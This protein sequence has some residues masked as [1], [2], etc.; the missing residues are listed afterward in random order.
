MRILNVICIIAAAAAGLTLVALAGCAPDIPGPE[1]FVAP[2]HG[3]GGGAGNPDAVQGGGDSGPQACTSAA[4]CP[5]PT[6]PCMAAVCTKGV[7]GAQEAA[8]GAACSDGIDCTNGDT[9]KAGKC[10]PVQSVCECLLDSDCVLKNKGDLCAGQWVCNP[11]DHK[12]ILNPKTIV[13]CPSIADTQCLKTE[14]VKATGKCEL[15]AVTGKPLCDDGDPCT[16]KEVC[17]DGVCTPSLSTCDCKS[18]ADCKDDSDLCNGTPYCDLTVGKCKPIPGSEVSCSQAGDT[19][20]TKNT[21]D[22]ATGKCAPEALAEGT[23]CA[24]GDVCKGSSTCKAGQCVGGTNL[25]PCGADPDCAKFDDGNLCNG[26]FYCDKSTK[27]CAVNPNTLPA[28]CP[29]AGNGACVTNTCDPKTSKCVPVTAANNTACSDGD[30]CSAG[31]YCSSGKCVAG[32]ATCDCGSD[33]DCAKYDDADLCNGK[34]VCDTTLKVCKLDAASVVAPCAAPGGTCQGSACDPKTGKCA[35]TNTADGVTCS[36]GNA[37]TATDKCSAGACKAG[38]N[39]CACQA[40]GD[41]IDDGNLCNGVP[42]CDKTGAAPVCKVKAGSEVKCAASAKACVVKACDPLTGQCAETPGTC[43][44]NNACTLDSCDVTSGQCKVSNAADGSGCDGGKVCAAGKCIVNNDDMVL[45][46][47]GKT[48]VGCTATEKECSPA[49]QPQHLVSLPAFFV[50][51]FEVTVA[52]YKACFETKKCTVP[53][54]APATCNLGDSQRAKHPINCLSWAAAEAYCAS[55]GKRLPTEAEFEMAARGPC[56]NPD[57]NACKL[58][59]KPFPWG[60][61]LAN[62]GTTWMKDAVK[63]VDGCNTGATAAVGYKPGDVSPT[64]VRDLGGN[65]SE[66]VKD[67]YDAGYYAKS[68]TDSPTNNA[69]GTQKVARGGNFTS[70]ASETRSARRQ[71]LESSG[72]Y[73][74]VGFRCAKDAK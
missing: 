60:L 72:T 31:D 16:D 66:W 50:D 64:G 29:T 69:A 65:V 24:S 48:W 56:A 33:G 32:P 35:T 68:P 53:A 18:S 71:G 8:D 22:K 43:T 21:C 62:C 46:A 13:T 14:C 7:C 26:V 28:P 17:I 47:A 36:D 19:A 49:E 15:K 11:V 52:H 40:D 42:Y 3:P 51:R 63:A 55:I 2:D 38:A 37:C 23:S 1:A 74:T 41:C 9:C 10:T 5:L 67:T 73:P 4:S 45:V 6:A 39:V 30:P 59:L 54:N 20:C 44:D 70:I 57:A 27:K 12:C 25:C 34:L 58:E 61:K